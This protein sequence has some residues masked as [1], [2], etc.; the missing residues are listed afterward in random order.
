MFREHKCGCIWS[1][2]LGNVRYCER[3]SRQGEG[4]GFIGAMGAKGNKITRRYP[5]NGYQAPFWN[6]GK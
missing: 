4:T 3:H 5:A 2:S 6:G 1:T